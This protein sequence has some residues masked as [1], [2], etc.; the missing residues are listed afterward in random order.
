MTPAPATPGSTTQTPR[1]PSTPGP[2]TPTNQAVYLESDDDRVSGTGDVHG[3]DHRGRDYDSME[4][5]QYDT[6]KKL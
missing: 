6:G 5:G 2:H 3:S 1:F 4:D